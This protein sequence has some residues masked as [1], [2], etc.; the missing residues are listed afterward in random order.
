MR[1]QGQEFEVFLGKYRQ[2]ADARELAKDY[3]VVYET[4]GDWAN[5]AGVFRPKDVRVLAAEKATNKIPDVLPAPKITLMRPPKYKGKRKAQVQVLMLSDT[6]AGTST[7]SYNPDVYKQRMKNLFNNL[8]LIRLLQ[9]EQHPLEKL[10]IFDLG[11]DVQGENV[12]FQM[13]LDQFIMPVF[14]QVFD[15][16]LP[17]MQDFLVSLLQVYRSIE[18]YGVR[19]NHGKLGKRVSTKVS[20]WDAVAQ[21]SL[22]MALANYKEISFTLQHNT[23]YLKAEVLGWQY[24]LTHGD[25]IKMNY[26]L[27][28]Y[29][30]DRK[31][32]RWAHEVG[33]VDVFCV[34]H[35]HSPFRLR[36]WGKPLLGNGC[37]PTDDEYA[38]STIGISGDP[39]QVTFGVHPERS[40]SWIYEL[41][42]G[43]TEV[44]I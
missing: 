6:H 37:F 33:P 22:K 20:N 13:D 30:I 21:R 32:S 19:G 31:T 11:D 2:G 15:L 12:G 1:P 38:I 5:A 36:P 17:T 29:G 44:V 7:P 14:N 27:P 23:F 18:Y 34:G 43:I 42:L 4:I 28:Y 35:F 39:V 26:T 25:V 9:S 24:L 3:G 8:C 41:D 16:W 10:V 40:I